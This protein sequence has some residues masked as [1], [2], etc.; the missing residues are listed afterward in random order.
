MCAKLNTSLHIICTK[1]CTSMARN[2]KHTMYSQVVSSHNTCQHM[3]Y[4]TNNKMQLVHFNKSEVRMVSQYSQPGSSS[5]VIITAWPSC[6]EGAMPPGGW[7]E[8]L[9]LPTFWSVNHLQIISR[10]NTS[11]CCCRI[12]HLMIP[13]KCT[14]CV[15][16]AWQKSQRQY[17]NTLLRN[18]STLAFLRA[19]RMILR[20]KTPW[21]WW[22]SRSDSVELGLWRWLSLEKPN[23]SY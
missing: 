12:N 4:L 8:K 23:P 19:Q 10:K 18:D 15:P 11:L 17:W 2:T 1:T 13:S 21:Q 14:D 5:Y 9:Q 22:L 20:G 3:P 6:T 7:R 16:T